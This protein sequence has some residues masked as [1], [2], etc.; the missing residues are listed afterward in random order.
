ML[1]LAVILAARFSYL[2]RDWMDHLGGDKAKLTAARARITYAII[3]LIV[4][5]GAFFIISIVGYIFRC[6]PTWIELRH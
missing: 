4:A 5:M 1:I 2:G 6:E 3:G